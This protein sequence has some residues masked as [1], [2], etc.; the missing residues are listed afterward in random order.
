MRFSLS[1]EA[2]EDIIVIAEQKCAHVR[3]RTGQAVS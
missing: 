1:I 3:I 2:E